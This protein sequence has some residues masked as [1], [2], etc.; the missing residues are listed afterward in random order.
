M[1]DDS[2]PDLG[3]SLRLAGGNR[4]APARRQSAHA[5]LWTATSVRSPGLVLYSRVSDVDA[6]SLAV[7]G[8]EVCTVNYLKA[9]GLHE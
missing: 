7:C 9:D 5:D 2:H 8:D 6:Q 4:T 1:K 3:G